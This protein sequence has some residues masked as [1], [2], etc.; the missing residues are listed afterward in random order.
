MFMYLL[1]GMRGSRNFFSPGRSEGYLFGDGGRGSKACFWSFYCKFKKLEFSRGGPA[2]PPSAWRGG[3]AYKTKT[4][5]KEGH[6]IY[7]AHAPHPL[8]VK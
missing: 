2:P 3:G 7:I 4:N 6:C 8:P 5:D 1:G